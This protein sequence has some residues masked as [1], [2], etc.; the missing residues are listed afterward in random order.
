MVRNKGTKYCI[1]P[2]IRFKYKLREFKTLIFHEYF[3]KISEA[4]VTVMFVNDNVSLVL[5]LRQRHI[6]FIV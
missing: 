1:T 5:S 3:A 4:C 2:N 6:I